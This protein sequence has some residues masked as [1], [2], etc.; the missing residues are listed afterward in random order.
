MRNEEMMPTEREWLLMEAIWDYEDGLGKNKIGSEE[1]ITSAEILKRVRTKSEMT[2]RTERV[3]LHH[4]VRKEIVGFTV[5]AS[6]SRVYHYFSKKNREECL[7][8]KQQDFI[9]IYYQ[10]SLVGAVASML[11]DPELSD[12]DIQELEK[13]IRKRKNDG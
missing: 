4:L 11:N 2:D 6:D 3:L 12:K 7:K 13:M 5:D 1:G 8:D 10:G 9:N